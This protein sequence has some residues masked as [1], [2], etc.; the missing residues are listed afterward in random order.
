MHERFEWQS[1]FELGF[2]EMD[3]THREFVDCVQALI[4]CDDAELPSAL[5]RFADHARAHF[6]EEDRWMAQTAYPSA[7]CHVDEHAAVLKSVDE[8]RALVERGR[9][10]V[11]RAL[12][13][14]LA[15]WFPGH[16]Q[17]MDLG[18][19]RWMVQRRLGGAPMVIHRRMPV[20][21]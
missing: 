10:D 12:G 6:A 9:F 8:V 17:M 7:G 4:A 1:E 21:A 11:A 15:R 14:E 5:A 3:D 16:A 18:L 20:A 2:E 13:A 19:A